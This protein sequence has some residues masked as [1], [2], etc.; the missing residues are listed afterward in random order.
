[1]SVPVPA[2]AAPL[3]ESSCRLSLLQSLGQI[4]D[5]RSR[6]GRRYP[7]DS[8][9]AL[10]IVALLCGCKN[11][12]Q[13]SVFGRN[14]PDLLKQLGFRAPKRSRRSEDRGPLRGPNEDT[15]ATLAAVAG[16]YLG[17]ALLGW[18]TAM[19]RPGDVA[20][21]DGKA[22]RG[23]QDHV[24]SVFV[25]RLRLVVWQAEVEKKEN[26]LSNLQ[27]NLAGLLEQFRPLTLLTGDAMF[28][29][30][31]IA[32]QI[33]EARRHYLFQLKGPHETDVALAAD[34]LKQLSTQPFLARSE[35]KRGAREAQCS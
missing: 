11:P 34:A 32:R 8:V 24:L 4:P 35:E 16:E 10:I 30:K 2:P 22:L 33:V 15:I 18:V 14:R 23:T 6:R 26:E 27:A 13:I 17:A 20:S 21:I 29:Q 25:S 31:E 5:K 9:L 7:L 3:D 1:M 28:C 12:S 19:L